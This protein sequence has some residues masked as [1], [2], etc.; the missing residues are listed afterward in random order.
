MADA[1]TEGSVAWAEEECGGM[2]T[3]LPCGAFLIG[4]GKDWGLFLNCN[5]V[6]LCVYVFYKVPP[7]CCVRGEGISG[8]RKDAAKPILRSWQDMVVA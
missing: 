6:T 7:G 5:K 3:D 4:H 8:A 2:Q 1:R